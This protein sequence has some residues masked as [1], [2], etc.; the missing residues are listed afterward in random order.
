MSVII[1]SAPLCSGSGSVCRLTG[2][3]R[4]ADHDELDAGVGGSLRFLGKATG[5]PAVLGHEKANGELLQQG[6]VQ[7]VGERP[8]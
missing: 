2:L 8:L 3:G 5:G 7:R 4:A 6:P 1:L